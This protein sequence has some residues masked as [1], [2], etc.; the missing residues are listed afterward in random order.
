MVLQK[1]WYIFVFCISYIIVSFGCF[2]ESYLLWLV[3]CA[4]LR[5]PIK[6]WITVVSFIYNRVT[7]RSILAIYNSGNKSIY[8]YSTRQGLAFRFSQCWFE[9]VY[10]SLLYKYTSS[11]M[12]YILPY[13]WKIYKYLAYLHDD[14]TFPS[15]IIL[16]AIF[17]YI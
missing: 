3:I 5:V 16:E 1:L 13:I 8:E 6:E 11:I 12:K 7:K 9:T 10:R 2:K 14:R 15:R 4:C 17:E